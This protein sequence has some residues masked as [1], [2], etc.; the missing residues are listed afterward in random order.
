MQKI[1]FSAWIGLR[2]NETRLWIVCSLWACWPNQCHRITEWIICWKCRN[3]CHHLALCTVVLFR[4]LLFSDHAC[5]DH[6]VDL[7]PM[8]SVW[9]LWS[10]SWPIG[11]DV[12]WL[13][14]ASPVKAWS[15]LSDPFGPERILQTLSLCVLCQ[16]IIGHT[17]LF[18]FSNFVHTY[19]L[20]AKKSFLKCDNHLWEPDQFFFLSSGSFSSCLPDSPN[21]T[22]PV[23]P[24]KC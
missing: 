20:W 19:P 5:P 13:W 4:V 22:S 15:L 1:V 12:V 18:P 14:L 6:W 17:I 3:F 21:M 23:L 16:F 11:C 9:H 24:L 8:V 10:H 2:E 7:L